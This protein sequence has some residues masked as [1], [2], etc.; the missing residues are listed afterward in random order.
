M[1]C[2]GQG[3]SLDGASL[4][5]HP[6]ADG[7]LVCHCF[8]KTAAEIRADII[9]LRLQTAD[10]VARSLLAGNG[11]TLCR[12]DI[13]RILTEVRGVSTGRAMTN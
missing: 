7:R 12:P 5:S 8:V 2:S 6:A 9:Q 13:E 3:A 10:D 1:F 4:D 11:C